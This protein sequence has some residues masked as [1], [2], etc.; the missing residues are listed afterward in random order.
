V[1]TREV[2]AAYDSIAATYDTAVADDAWI[3]QRL[4]AHYLSRFRSGQRV[5]DLFCGTG[6]DATFL[7]SRGI[8]VVGLDASAGML[9]ECRHK[10][11]ALAIDPLVETRLGDVSDLAALPPSQLDGAVSAF[12]GLNAVADL[13]QVSIGVARALRPGSHFVAHFVNRFS[14][15]EALD[16][17][18]RGRLAPVWRMYRQNVRE[19]PIGG[20]LVPHY[21]YGPDE[22]Y[23]RFFNTEFHLRQ[24]YGLGILQPPS[25]VHRVPPVARAAAGRIEH[26]S[27]SWPVIRAMGRWF[28]ID[29]ERR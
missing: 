27:D 23:K 7:A 11:V 1:S 25:S 15:W 14:L 13:R 18:T 9:A 29:L 8:H 19:F 26:A 4:W 20:K 22:T 5:L 3:R 12:G 16:Y 28:V 2:A 17:V 10:I 24:A 21:L 6:I